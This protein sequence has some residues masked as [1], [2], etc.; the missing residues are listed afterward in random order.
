MKR[1]LEPG[2]QERGQQQRGGAPHKQ[3]AAQRLRQVAQPRLERALPVHGAAARAA[4]Q[5][6]RGRAERL[7]WRQQR[8]HYHHY[9]DDR[10]RRVA[11]RQSTRGGVRG[12]GPERGKRAEGGVRRRGRRRPGSGEGGNVADAA[13]GD[14]AGESAWAPGTVLF[15]TYKVSFCRIQLICLCFYMIRELSSRGFVLLSFGSYRPSYEKR[16]AHIVRKKV[17]LTFY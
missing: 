2:R 11:R 3:T 16:N 7:R 8:N 6:T 13:H 1:I 12:G 10:D 14:R 9:H 5:A 4:A 17:I 15:L